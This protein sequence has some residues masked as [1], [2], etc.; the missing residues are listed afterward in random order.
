MKPRRESHRWTCCDFGFALTSCAMD[1]TLK[2]AIATMAHQPAATSS[3]RLVACRDIAGRPKSV[4]N[5][6]TLRE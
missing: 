3:T 5:L 6:S 2:M 4:S 1:R